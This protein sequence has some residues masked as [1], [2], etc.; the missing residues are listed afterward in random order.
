LRSNGRVRG[1]ATEISND[2]FKYW[3]EITENLFIGEPDDTIAEPFKFSCA[4]LISGTF[5]QS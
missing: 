2:E 3:I 1:L 5:L 4:L